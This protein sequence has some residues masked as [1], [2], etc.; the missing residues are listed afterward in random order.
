VPNALRCHRALTSGAQGTLAGWSG[1]VPQR[2]R[3]VA[4]LDAFRS[5][6]SELKDKAPRE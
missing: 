3:V 2:K 5:H 1:D 4:R 6:V